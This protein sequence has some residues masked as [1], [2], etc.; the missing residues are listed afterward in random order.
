MS[1][2]LSFFHDRVLFLND[3]HHLRGRN[4]LTS[5]DIGI[6]YRQRNSISVV[7]WGGEVRRKGDYFTQILLFE[8]K[9]YLSGDAICVKSRTV[10]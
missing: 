9:C 3:D 2:T 10:P 7:H 8:S 4:G 5:R 1:L 6:L